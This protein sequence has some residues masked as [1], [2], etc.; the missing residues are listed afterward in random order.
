MSKK[1]QE[2]SRRFV[3]GALGAGAALGLTRVASAAARSSAALAA[4]P[5]PAGEPAVNGAAQEPGVEPS[6]FEGLVT[7]LVAGSRLGPWQVEQLVST[8]VGTLS[9]LM[10]GASGARFQLDVC[11]RDG[12]LGAPQSPGNTE[13]FQVFVANTGDGATATLEEQGL[14]AMALA[15]VIR[16]NE[17]A[18]NRSGFLTLGARNAMDGAR[19]HRPS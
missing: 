17:Q 2:V 3:V 13:H 7:P 5:T 8:A 19:L 16:G 10:V 12:S 14:A 9:V 18:F 6:H 1:R 15:D 4:S 11:A